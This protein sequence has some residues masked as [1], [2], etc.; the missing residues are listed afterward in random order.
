MA[1]HRHRKD[2]AVAEVEDDEKKVVV[3]SD[4]QQKQQQLKRS[5]KWKK[6]NARTVLVS[7]LPSSIAPD[8][9]SSSTEPTL[10]LTK[11]QLFKKLRKFGT[12]QQL[13]FPEPLLGLD[14]DAAEDALTIPTQGSSGKDSFSY[15]YFV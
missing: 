4:L 2:K 9:S 11:K 7:R 8:A 15:S 14:G 13:H 10:T 6:L 12:V 3:V 1:K 5:V